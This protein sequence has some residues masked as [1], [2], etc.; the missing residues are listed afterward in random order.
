MKPANIKDQNELFAALLT[1][2]TA[3]EMR[4]FLNDLCTP[5]ELAAFAERWA[6]AK[7]LNNGELG[8]R[9]IAAKTGASTTTVGRVARFLFQENHNGY[10]LA[11]DRLSSSK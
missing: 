9:E 7:H 1:L 10:K 8:Y 3:E 6:I 4:A 11:M 2:E 5:G